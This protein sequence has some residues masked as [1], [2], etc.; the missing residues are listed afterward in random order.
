[1]DLGRTTPTFRMFDTARAKEFYV[2]FLGFRIDW[3]HG[4]DEGLPLYMQVSRGAC[5]I[6]L[7]EH[8]G[9]SCPGAAVRIE[10]SDLDSLHR[11][12]IGKEYKYSR[13]GIET[14]PWGTRDMQVIDPSG[15]RLI[16][17]AGAA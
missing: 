16:F 4:T 2:D 3:E 6:H 14:M 5:V 15:N 10:T 12:L 8:H 7:S 11:E 1:M 9:D 17:T 13:P